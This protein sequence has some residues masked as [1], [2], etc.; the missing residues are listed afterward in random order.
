MLVVRPEKIPN[1]K[2]E[3]NMGIPK[4]SNLRLTNRGNGI[5]SPDSL[6]DQSSTKMRAPKRDVPAI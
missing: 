5:F 4:R 3:M 1:K 6:K 2:K